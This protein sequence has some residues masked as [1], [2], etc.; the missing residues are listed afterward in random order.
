MAFVARRLRLLA[1]GTARGA[2]AE[3]HSASVSAVE[4][5]PGRPSPIADIH[6]PRE[7]ADAD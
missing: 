6:F 1:L 4:P 2:V 5:D 3:H 7:V